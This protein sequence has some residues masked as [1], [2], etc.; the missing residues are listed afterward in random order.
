MRIETTRFGT[1]EVE[2]E[3]SIRFPEGLPG[4]PDAHEF[5]LLEHSPDSPFHWLQNIE[6]PSLAFV[7]MDPLLVEPRYLESIPSQALGGLG[8]EEARDAAVLSIVTIDRGNRRITAN[9][10]APLV[11]H[12][13]TRQGRQVILMESAYTTKHEIASWEPQS[14][15]ATNGSASETSCRVASGG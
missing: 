3:R 8:L 9:L 14:T 5:L 7:V 12:P 1:L 15:G 4:F 13:G 6:D 2:E 11:I 10:M